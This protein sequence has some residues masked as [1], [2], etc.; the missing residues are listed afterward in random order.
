LWDVRTH[1]QLGTPLAGHT[2]GVSGVAFSP[3]GRTLASASFDKTLRLWD[4]L[5]WRNFAEL[6]R[7]VCPLV[8]TGLSRSEWTQTD[9]SVAYRNSCP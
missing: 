1:K 5:L 2:S 9:A 7:E 4:G 6:Q 3:D 8:G